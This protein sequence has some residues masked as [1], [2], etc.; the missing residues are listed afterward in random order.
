MY[1]HVDASVV[2]SKGIS[3]NAGEEGRVASFG[4]LDAQVRQYAVSQNFFADGV[5]RIALRVQSLVVHVPQNANWFFSLS[6]ALKYSRFS[7]SC[8][9]I[10]Q[11]DLKVGWSY[12][13]NDIEVIVEIIKNKKLTIANRLP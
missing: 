1:D 10:L 8:S 4:S 3:G 9:L 13:R 11:F 5:T 12:G 2:A 6:L 7:S